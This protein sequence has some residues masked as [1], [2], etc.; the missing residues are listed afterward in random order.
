M[1]G[2]GAKVLK[3]AGWI[4]CSTTDVLRH[5]CY[6]TCCCWSRSFVGA[7]GGGGMQFGGWEWNVCRTAHD[8][9]V[10]HWRPLLYQRWIHIQ[11]GG[12]G[13]PAIGWIW[14]RVRVG[15]AR[16]IAH[17]GQ[18][19]RDAAQSPSERKHRKKEADSAATCRTNRTFRIQNLTMPPCPFTTQQRD[20]G[21]VFLLVSPA[22]F[23]S[24][25]HLGGPGAQKS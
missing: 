24:T 12:G 5:V 6:V 25:L 19:I 2:G 23:L 14:D 1:G 13:R 22:V 21:L 9:S 10:L 11:G 8:G 3:K 18:H 16:H 17:H 7:E 4:P 15:A 20:S